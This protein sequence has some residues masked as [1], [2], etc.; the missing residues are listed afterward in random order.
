LKATAEL[1]DLAVGALVRECAIRYA[2]TVARE[3]RVSGKR[4]RRGNVVVPGS[5]PAR[6]VAKSRPVSR[7]AAKPIVGLK[8]ASDLV[9]EGGTQ[10][11]WDLAR[12]VKLN[13]A[14]VRPAKKGKRGGL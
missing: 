7:S 9:V 6:S 11:D 12:Q 13:E 10:A 3:L 2:S 14:R 1:N 8:R 4:L 5:G